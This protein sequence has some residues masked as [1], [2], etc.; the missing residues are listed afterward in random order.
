MKEKLKTEEEKLKT[1]VFQ[2]KSE[3]EYWDF[4][5]LVARFAF[6]GCYKEQ[7]F[8]QSNRLL[9]VNHCWLRLLRKKCNSS[10]EHSVIWTSRTKKENA[11]CGNL[12][13]SGIR[14]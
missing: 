6:S 2:V 8:F 10:L 1:E 9:R 3:V 4:C 14:C 7:I 11:I 13:Q 5:V 12:V